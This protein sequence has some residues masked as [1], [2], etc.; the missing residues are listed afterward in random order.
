MKTIYSVIFLPCLII[1]LLV[2]PV[3][4]SSDDWVEFGRLTN[5]DV[6]L[7]NKVRIK[8]RTKDIVQV[9]DKCVYSDEGRETEIQE[10][11]KR[12]SST[13]GYDNL[14]NTMSLI[15]IDCKKQM[16]QF[17]SIT[18]YDT[19]GKILFNHSYDN[20]TWSHILPESAMDVLRG[21]VCK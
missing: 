13:E 7:Y 20:P 15:E 10:K 19:D 4:G 16:S 5:G 17:L 1:L 14:S 2:T 8:H 12:G 6:F 9:W 18:D 21:K 3:I 11:R